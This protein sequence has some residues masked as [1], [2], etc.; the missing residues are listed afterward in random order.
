MDVYS[1]DLKSDRCCVKNGAKIKSQ[2]ELQRLALLTSTTLA[3]NGRLSVSD[4][5][6]SAHM[7]KSVNP[8]LDTCTRKDILIH[9]TI[10]SSFLRGIKTKVTGNIVSLKRS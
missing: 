5:G 3:V 1:S 9:L 7:L 8:L 2:R 10:R 4:S 6:T